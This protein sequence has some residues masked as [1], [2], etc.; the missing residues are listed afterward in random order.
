MLKV[1]RRR[2]I[3]TMLSA[4]RVF[5]TILFLT[6][7]AGVPQF[8]LVTPA[9]AAEP[10]SLTNV[11]L[12]IYPEYDDP[13]LLMMLDGYLPQGTPIPATIR[14]LV[15][16][17]AAMNSAGYWDAQGKYK[18][19]P[20]L[21]GGLPIR[22]ASTVAG[23]DEINFDISTNRFRME[24]YA[25][26]IVGLPD[27]KIAFEFRPLYPIDS[28]QVFILQPAK[29]TNFTVAPP[30]QNKGTIENMVSHQYRLT[31]VGIEKPVAYDIAYTKAD[32]TPSLNPQTGAASGSSPNSNWLFGLVAAVV[33][34]G[35]AIWY[36]SKRRRLRVAPKY[37]GARTG[38]RPNTPVRQTSSRESVSRATPA[39]SGRDGTGQQGAVKAGFCRKCGARMGAN[40]RFCPKCGAQNG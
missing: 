39:K 7:L 40:P 27:K 23:W 35:G 12:D 6:I 29:A 11:T 18:P 19:S 5:S 38:Q 1:L 24:Y 9:L 15:P 10:P 13:R 25:D 34:I 3:G 32:S 30:A 28:L 8:T 4:V 33:I 20:T 31:N 14:F 36:G 22:K 21:V 16:T 37:R 17:G 26:S 2:I